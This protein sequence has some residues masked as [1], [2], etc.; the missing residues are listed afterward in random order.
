M[1]QD[2]EVEQ[3]LTPGEMGRPGSDR[4]ERGGPFS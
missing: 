1:G 3:A 4:W 2:L